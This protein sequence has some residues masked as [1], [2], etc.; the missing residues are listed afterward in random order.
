[1]VATDMP[2]ATALRRLIYGY[3][4]TFLVAAAAELGLADRLAD[5]PLAVDALAAATGAHPDA[6]R[7]V[8]VALAQLG[9]LA[10]RPGDRF[11]LTPVGERLRADDPDGLAAFAR[12]QAHAFIQRPW[13][14]LPHTVRTGETAFD[15][16]FGASPFAYLAAHPDAAALFT[17][18]MAARTREH[19]DAIVTS[20]AWARYGTII[21]VGGADGTLLTAILPAAPAARGVVFDL[22]RLRAAAEER[23]AAAGLAGR[24][25]FVGGDFFAAELPGGDAYLLKYV[26][27]DWDDERAVAI[28]RAVRRAAPAHARLLAIERLLPEG[29]EP[30]LETTMLD[31]GMLVVAGGR[32]RTAGEYAA[33]YERAGFRLAR[34][35]DTSSP[36]SL[37]EGEP[38]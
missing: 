27:H 36:F 1:M 21:D 37:V 19:L 17:A 3:Q 10:R 30:A 7:R 9:L 11:G 32:E 4:A 5:G 28:L 25:A 12:Y 18:G 31:I 24:C 23:I 15:A 13:A 20:Y 38:V 22:P 33:L 8:L 16:V 6:L 14:N 2:P 26:L 34:V 29:D 35:V